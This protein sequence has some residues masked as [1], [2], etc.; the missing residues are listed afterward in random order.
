MIVQSRKSKPQGYE[1]TH[2]F[3]HREPLV[4]SFACWLVG[5]FIYSKKKKYFPLPI[6][7]FGECLFI[8]LNHPQSP[9]IAINQ[10]PLITINQSPLITMNQSPLI[11]INQSP[12][13]NH[14]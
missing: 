7:S 10:S 3:S 11:T 2:G 1:Y 4:S 6:Q 14:H 8:T 13:I 12:L 9:F 5:Y